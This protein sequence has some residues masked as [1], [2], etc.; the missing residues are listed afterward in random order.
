M[1]NYGANRKPLFNQLSNLWT[2]LQHQVILLSRYSTIVS[3]LENYSKSMEFNQTFFDDLLRTQVND[4]NRI[5][6]RTSVCLIPT[7]TIAI[8]LGEEDNGSDENIIDLDSIDYECNLT[9][10]K[11]TSTQTVKSHSTNSIRTTTVISKEQD[12]QTHVDKFTNVP[13]PSNFVFGLRGRKDDK[14]FVIDLT[15]SIT[16]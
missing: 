12:T 13:T 14:Q 8:F 2:N 11:T 3:N 15:R 7:S 10:C 6:E 1:T 9:K 4:E 5:R 16:K